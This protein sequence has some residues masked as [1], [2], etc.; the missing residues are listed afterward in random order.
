MIYLEN[1]VC[2]PYA[3]ETEVPKVMFS[4]L[5]YFSLKLIT[6]KIKYNFQFHFEFLLMISVS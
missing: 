4:V 2:K 5:H 1:T 6:C 3:I